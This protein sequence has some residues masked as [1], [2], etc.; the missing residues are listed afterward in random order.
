VGTGLLCPSSLKLRL[1]AASKGTQDEIIMQKLKSR[2]QKFA[3]RLLQRVHEIGLTFGLIILPNHYYVPFSD[4]RVLRRTR[5]R[6]AHRSAMLG[7]DLDL[8]RQE[9]SLREMVKPFEVEYR[10]NTAYNFAV[11]GLFGPGFGYIEAQALHG[12]IRSLKPRRIVEIGS[13]VSTYCMLEAIKRNGSG[14]QTEVTCIEPYPRP[15][16]GQAPVKLIRNQ[17]QEVPAETFSA[18]QH[19]DLLFIDSTH[20]VRVDG[21][22]NRIVLEI[23]PRLPP[24]IVVHFHDIFLPYDYPLDADRSIFQWMETALLHAFLIG[25]RNVE[26]LFCLSQ[27]HYD[28]RDALRKVFPEYVPHED[29]NGLITGPFDLTKHFPSSLYLRTKPA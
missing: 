18:L 1:R 25:N 24:G 8:D 17:L 12:V 22:V 7:I 13:G 3:K 29:V 28:R 15:W 10:G 14:H 23:L 5:A 26:I 19:G 11:G 27:L 6:W 2:G 9:Q 21:D 16:L 4:L 20:T